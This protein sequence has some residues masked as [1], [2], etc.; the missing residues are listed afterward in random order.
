MKLRFIYFLF[1]V[2]ILTIQ[3]SNSQTIGITGN[4]VSVIK[5]GGSNGALSKI[6]PPQEFINN[7]NRKSAFINVS[8]DSNFDDYPQ[9]KNAFQYAVDILSTQIQSRV[10]IE[11]DARFDVLGA[12]ILGNSRPLNFIMN[13][14][15]TPISH[16]YSN[17]FYPIALANKIVGYDLDV[18][19]KDILLKFNSSYSNFYFGTDGNTPA[20]KYDFVTLVLH[21]LI[22]GLGFFSPAKVEATGVGYFGFT[23]YNN[24][25]IYDKFTQNS[26][27]MFTSN[28][29][30]ATTSL[31]SHL[32][33]NN[34]YFNGYDANSNNNN[35][36]PKIYT[37]SIWK[38]GSSYAHW[39]ESYFPKGNVNSLMTPVL[40]YAESIH[41]PGNVTKG[42]L[43]DLGWDVIL[44]TGVNDYI[45]ILNPSTILAQGTNYQFNATFI[46]EPPYTVPVSWSWEIELY[47]SGGKM[48]LKSYTVN[49][50]V[51]SN[52]WNINIGSL[53]YGYNWL[54][55]CNG[56]VL[57]KLKLKCKDSDGIYHLDEYQIGIKETPNQP[58]LKL[59]SVGNNS[60]TFSFYSEGATSYKIYYDT[61]PGHPYSGTQ[62]TQGNSGISY[63]SNNQTSYTLSGL[64]NAT[65][66]YISVKGVNSAGESVYS[67]EIIAKPNLDGLINAQSRDNNSIFNYAIYPN[68]ANTFLNID[69]NIRCDVE[70]IDQLGRK[71]QSIS[72]EN[73]K[74][75]DFRLDI[76]NLNDGIFFLKY[77]DPFNQND[78]KINKF[79][80]IH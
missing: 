25:I 2:F 80:V 61:D 53:I 33:S 73:I 26:S 69:N 64:N 77:I 58:I 48:I 39:D 21:E 56:N 13:F 47:H 41:N 30:N 46:D 32:T 67:Y 42:L 57:G 23:N 44:N 14:N 12:G 59:T 8:Y 7:P 79:I 66:Y 15:S 76:S 9:A 18:S 54:R 20:G 17:V 19:G 22:H 55:D 60:A 4:V 37:P 36:N 16:Y 38:S 31:G 35:V 27:G 34:L 49:Q 50:M 6:P 78:K 24:P 63:I 40:N 65:N 71:V 62:A 75:N 68:P 70:I 51:Y 1:F 28:F 10:M 5:A 29:I 45:Y 52:T 3:K 72:F 43:M 11:V 74:S